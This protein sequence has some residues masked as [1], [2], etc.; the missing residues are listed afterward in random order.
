MRLVTF[1]MDQN[2]IYSE[3]KLNEGLY[4]KYYEFE[5]PD[6]V[7]MI[8]FPDGCIDIQLC[9]KMGK[10]SLQLAGSFDNAGCAVSSDY[11]KIVA[12][13]FNPGQIPV[14][15][16]NRMGDIISN[17][18][19]ITDMF[20]EKKLKWLVSDAATVDDRIEFFKKSF[21][22]EQISKQHEIVENVIDI[23]EQ[24]HGYISISDMVDMIGYSHRYSDRVFK[25]AIGFSIKKYASII[26]LQE[27][28]RIVNNKRVDDVYNILG[29][30]DQSHFIH[31]FKKFTT[32][33]PN[34]FSKLG[35]EKKV[36]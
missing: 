28:I 7:K 35:N 23:I 4:Y 11:E 19:D 30:Y 2:I 5:N 16:E 31:D 18:V 9:V 27:A 36:V 29:Y 12:I 15:L 10:V 17:R 34:A 14:M 24:Y 22:E 8:A 20:D 26:R 1:C 21:G 33:T 13:K 32:F 25:E 3:V 6:H